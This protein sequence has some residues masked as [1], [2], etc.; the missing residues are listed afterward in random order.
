MDNPFLDPRAI[1]EHYTFIVEGE[2]SNKVSKVRYRGIDVSY[3][4][5]LDGGGRDFGQDFIPIVRERLGRVARACEFGCGPGFIGFSLLAHGLCDS[6]CLIDVNPEAVK[7]VKRTIK[8]NHLEG[9]V[10]VYLSDGLK[11]IPESEKWDLVVSNPPHFGGTAAEWRGDMRIF[12]PK[13]RIHRDFYRSVP[14]FL[15]RKGSVMFVENEMG[16]KPEMWK[17]EAIRNGLEWVGS[18]KVGKVHGIIRQTATVLHT[19][20]RVQNK[21]MSDQMGGMLGMIARAPK[22]AYYVCDYIAS[23]PFYF[24]WSRK[25]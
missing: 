18:F 3:L 24:V 16:S 4:P 2:G 15:N 22:T 14:R 11:E 17:K 12:D 10:S 21:K 9:R 1:R 19:L 6:L 5:R 13:W 23:D 8:E 7:I 20:Q 25:R